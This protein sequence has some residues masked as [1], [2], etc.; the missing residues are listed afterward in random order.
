M[1]DKKSN[2][3]DAQ[4]KRL[5]TLSNHTE[6]QKQ[7][8]LAELTRYPVI[9]A[10]VAKVGVGRATFYKWLKEDKEFAELASKTR[11][12][13]QRFINDLAE[14]QI[15]RHIQDGYFPSCVYWLRHHHEDYE[16]RVSQK[17]E[18]H[19]DIESVR[20]LTREEKESIARALHNLGLAGVIKMEQELRDK[21][22]RQE[23]SQEK[24]KEE[25]IEPGSNKGKK[26]KDLLTKEELEHIDEL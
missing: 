3:K 10:A 17:H 7:A 20:Q 1:A 4:Q 18:H 6:R 2:R 14:S 19:I 15:I 8:V 24:D 21:I 9:Q 12:D 26:L 13:G 16:E 11:I 5:D 22:T 23:T 25:N